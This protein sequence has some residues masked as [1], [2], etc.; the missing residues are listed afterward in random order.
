MLTLYH[1]LLN[2]KPLCDEA[3]YENPQM[4]HNT[5]GCETEVKGVKCNLFLK[6]V[7]K[8]CV[9]HH[10]STLVQNTE[11]HTTKSPIAWQDKTQR[12]RPRP[13]GTEQGATCESRQKVQIKVTV[14]I[15]VDSEVYADT[16][17]QQQGKISICLVLF[18]HQ[19]P[20]IVKG[21]GK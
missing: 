3:E 13:T 10:S 14:N 4:F 12:A 20:V 5:Q 1:Q 19:V 15:L 8:T 16:V 21:D 6:S 9:R 11:E 18:L 2:L 17:P 7:S